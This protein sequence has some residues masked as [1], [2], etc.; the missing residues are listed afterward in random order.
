MSGLIEQ[1]S[2]NRNFQGQLSVEELSRSLVDLAELDKTSE[3]QKLTGYQ[4]ALAGGATI[5]AGFMV[6]GSEFGSPVFG[7]ALGIIGS[8]MLLWGLV[9]RGK[10]GTTDF[11]DRRYQ[12]VDRLNR[13]IGVDMA[14]NAKLDLTLNLEPVDIKHKLVNKGKAGVWNVDYYEDSWLKL[15]GKLLD[16]TRFTLELTEKYQY[17]H[18]KKRS[19]SGKIKHKSK[20]KYAVQAIVSLK[21]K[22][23]RYP[24]AEQLG[25]QARGA[26]QLPQATQVKELSAQD[27]VLTLK[28]ARKGKHGCDSSTDLLSGMLL[29]LYQVLNLSRKI[30]KSQSN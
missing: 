1:L 14:P 29:S 18:R 24:D 9:S 16:G 15:R 19:A 6:I 12:L 26:L 27:N 11:E 25:Q 13:L 7:W 8:G 23:K 21:P 28:T 10:A 30:G 3:K 20:T 17:R 22:E 5:V 4:F 2:S